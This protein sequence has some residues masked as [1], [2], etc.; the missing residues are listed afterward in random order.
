M[1]LMD[2]KTKHKQKCINMLFFFFFGKRNIN[3]GKQLM[4]E[5]E[6]T[7]QKLYSDKFMLL[8][9]NNIMSE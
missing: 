7:L 8:L 1:K 3:D 4:T 6:S 2:K 9:Y 5:N